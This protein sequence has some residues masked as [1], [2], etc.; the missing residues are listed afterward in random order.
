MPSVCKPL[1]V[2]SPYSLRVISLN[3]SSYVAST[4]EEDCAAL[5]GL[6]AIAAVAA[7]AAAVGISVAIA[8]TLWPWLAGAMRL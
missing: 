1:P 2:S 7:A 8:A 6:A 4:L 5:A 3:I